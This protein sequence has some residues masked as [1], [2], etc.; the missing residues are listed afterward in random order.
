MIIGRPHAGLRKEE[1]TSGE[2]TAA[3]GADAGNR[4]F[5]RRKHFISGNWFP[6]GAISVRTIADRFRGARYIEYVPKGLYV[7]A[8]GPSTHDN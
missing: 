2:I 5:R 1:L 3:S 8:S 6:S 7:H 4:V